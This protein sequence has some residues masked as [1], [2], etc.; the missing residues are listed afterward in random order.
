MERDGTDA[1]GWWREAGAEALALLLPVW[2]AGCDR[3]G[4]AF[5]DACATASADPVRRVVPSGPTV[6]TAMRFE[7]A[8]ARAV[9]ALKEDGRT[10]VAR[11]L[12][13]MVADVLA[14]AGWGGAALVPVPTSRAA[15]RR[16][17]YAVPELVARH[18]GHRVERALRVAAVPA[19]DQRLLRRDERARNVAGAFAAS[20]RV[21]G[22]PV[23]VVD[24]VVTTGATLR[25]AARA[26]E[27]CGARVLGAVAA[28]DT[29][30]RIST[31]VRE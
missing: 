7:G 11:P 24:D 14:A 25:E 29:P 28:A 27:A 5:C 16:R 4:R 13:G 15:L 22:H 9:R 12:G 1:A 23:V 26:L 19:A 18:T 6:W 20:R 8:A 10:G 31:A 30:R 2:C 21:E 3:P 17:G